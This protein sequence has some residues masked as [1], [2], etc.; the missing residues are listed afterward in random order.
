MQWADEV[1]QYKEELID[2]RR[3][4]HMNPELSFHESKTA[5]FIADYLTKLDIPVTTNVG[6]HGLFG[7]ISGNAEGP[8]VLLR[9]DIDALSIQDQKDVPYRSSVPGVMHACGHDGHTA[10]LLITAKILKKHESEIKGNVIVCFQHA[11]EVLPGGAISMIEAG[12]LTD[13]DYVFGAH[14]SS[15]MDT[16]N[17]GFITGPAYGI[18]DDINITVQG[19][20][21][22]GATPHVTHD[23]IIAAS[24]L[25]SQ[26]QTIVSRN[27]DP[28]ETGVV[29]IGEF[30][31][32]DAFNVI[33]DSVKLTGT[34]RSYKE[35]V[36]AIIIERLKEISKGI[37]QSFNIHVD[38]KYTHGY[39]ALIN[40]ERETLWLQSVAEKTNGI[41][42]VVKMNRT[43]G[44]ED[45]A[46]FL[47]NR[48]G[49]YFNVGVKNSAIQA[50]FP[51]HHPKF[52][53]DEHGLL[54]G[55]RVFLSLVE[56]M[57]ELKNA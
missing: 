36:K 33:A 2:I 45:F 54:N 35:D 46:Y 13:V 52:D 7:K 3:Y 40:S 47:Q 18:A 50:D 28:I 37:E 9:A 27:V 4:L 1:I 20:G 14:T 5:A 12:V 22:H 30:K 56:R 6:G 43:L 51:H 34:V 31:G 38:F 19:K 39:P 8:T 32:G 17:V 42:N 44:G 16:G 10:M 41:K 49:T 24:H 25:I 55:P 11:E 57:D 26:F 15:A 48:P 29:T 21:G 23:A 53:M